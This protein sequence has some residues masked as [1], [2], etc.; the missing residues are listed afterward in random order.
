ML[1]RMTPFGIISLWPRYQLAQS[2]LK[3]GFPLA[4][5]VG[6][7]EVGGNIHATHMA[8]ALAGCRTALF[9]T[10]WTI[11]HLVSTNGHRNHS[12]PLVGAPFP[13]L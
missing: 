6:Y 13:D 9:G 4:K 7:G 11:S 5:K 1:P 12:S 10:G 3:I 8:A 2:V